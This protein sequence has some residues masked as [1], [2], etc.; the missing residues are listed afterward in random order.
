MKKRCLALYSGGLDSILAVKVMQDQGVDVISLYFVSPFFGLGALLEPEKYRRGQLE[1]YGI[2]VHVVDFTDDIIRILRDPPHGFGRHLNPCID[3][4][5]GMLRKARRLLEALDAAFIVTGEVLGQRP[6]SQRR[7]AMNLIEREA[8]LKGLLLRPLCALNMAAS[9]P[10]NLG[11]VD[12][13]HLLSITGRGR[14]QQHR[15][16]QHYGIADVDIPTPAGGCLLTDEQIAPKVKTTLQR[17]GAG[18]PSREDLMLDVVG[19]KFALSDTTVLVISRNDRENGLMSSFMAPGNLFMKIGALPGPLSILRGE[20]S[21]DNLSRAAAICLR[22]GKG[23][24]RP[25]CRAFFGESPSQLNESIEAPVIT[26]DEC[27]SFQI[28]L[29][30]QSLL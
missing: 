21:P 18:E 15:L 11:V 7:D 14:K 30:A 13:E 22:Y 1:K 19:R 9:V 25:G 28:D 17:C 3:C 10:E 29:S 20:A 16:A 23:R 5:I 6:M 27:R 2:D 24:G 12:R 4:K 8:D 26:D